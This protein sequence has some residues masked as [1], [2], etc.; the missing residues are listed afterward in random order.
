MDTNSSLSQTKLFELYYKDALIIRA[1][2][3]DLNF[4]AD[5]SPIFVNIHVRGPEHFMAPPM[6]KMVGRDNIQGIFRDCR[7]IQMPLKAV[8]ITAKIS[9]VLMTKPD[10]KI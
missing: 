2:C 10:L 9:S 7:K 8:T 6:P 1:I 4:P 5:Y 3:D